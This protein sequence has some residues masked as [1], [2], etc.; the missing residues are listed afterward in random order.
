MPG[1]ARGQRAFEISPYGGL[2]MPQGAFAKLSEGGYN[3]GIAA[4]IFWSR[5]FGLG[6]DFND[7]RNGFKP[8]YDYGR[9]P[10]AD[11]V[12]YAVSISESGAWRARSIALGPTY[13]LG[14]K[15]LAASVYAKAGVAKLSG[16]RSSVRFAFLGLDQDL[17][18]LEDTETTAFSL[19]SGVRLKTNLGSRVSLFINPQLVYTPSNTSFSYRDLDKAFS[20]DPDTGREVFSPSALV[21]QPA[22]K[23]KVAQ[24]YLNYS[25]GVTF[26]L[27]PLQE[28]EK[29]DGLGMYYLLE[30]RFPQ[31]HVLHRGEYLQVQFENRH[32][33]SSTST[34]LILDVEDQQSVRLKFLRRQRAVPSIMGLNRL[35]IK[36]NDYR[37]QPGRTYLLT[38]SDLMSNYYLMFKTPARHEK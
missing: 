10:P 18:S 36:L 25:I 3:Y 38:V 34:Y 2:A 19:T 4:D 6:F 1:L 27:G 13:R 16:P 31:N 14:G 15:R 9:I 5:S 12:P 22:I 30:E 26:S 8:L 23:D 24:A 32:A 35:Q 33:S 28:K 29:E 20:R 37:V 17:F 7:Q 21:A 11:I